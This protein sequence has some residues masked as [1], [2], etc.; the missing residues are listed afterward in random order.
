MLSFSTMLLALGSQVGPKMWYAFT[1]LHLPQFLRKVP[2][3]L[4][5]VWSYNMPTTSP[6]LRGYNHI[7]VCELVFSR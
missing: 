3:L 1:S 7:S 6:V 4:A 2:E 5:V